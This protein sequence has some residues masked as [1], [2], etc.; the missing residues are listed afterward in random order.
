MITSL[1]FRASRVTDLVAEVELPGLP[2]AALRVLQ[3]SQDPANGPEELSVPI[4]SDVGLASQVLRFVNSSYFGLSHKVGSVKHAVTLVGVKATRDFVV[5]R[6]IY[7]VMPEP[8]CGGLNMKRLWQD[9]LRRA[10]FARA[11][12]CDWGLEEAEEVFTGALL[13]DMAVP[14]LTVAL[15][16][17][18][19]P[20]LK[21]RETKSAPLSKLEQQVFGWTH[22]SI[23]GAVARQWKLPEKFAVLIENHVRLEEL[24]ASPAAKDPLLAVA[25]SAML[26]PAESPWLEEESFERHFGQLHGARGRSL[27]ELARDVD[28]QFAELAPLLK[29]PVPRESLAQ[30]LTAREAAGV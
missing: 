12:A 23:A 13:Q 2:E 15:P 3:L 28:S 4:E 19:D 7:N 17:V 6:A 20:L 22:A 14:L 29:I 16:R 5:W 8:T 9:S 1:R 10:L 11:V 21:M 26:P 24:S 27:L 30:L 25:L 18:Y